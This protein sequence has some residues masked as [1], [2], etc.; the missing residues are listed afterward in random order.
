MSNEDPMDCVVEFNRLVKDLITP[1]LKEIGFKR[2]GLNFARNSNDII[3]TFGIQKERFNSSDHLSFKL[4][5][6]LLSEEIFREILKK[7]M[8]P[9]PLEVFSTIRLFPDS[10]SPKCK[11]KH[12]FSVYDE[13]TSNEI[14]ARVQNEIE[15][16]YIPFF[17]KYNSTNTWAELLD[18]NLKGLFI[19]PAIQRFLVYLKIGRPIQAAEALRNTY[20]FSLL[21]HSKTLKYYEGR[22]KG[23][24]LHNATSISRESIEQIERFAEKYHISLDKDLA[25]KLSS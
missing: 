7:E 20:S 19:V 9:F 1:Q 12:T 25:S 10:V 15:H 21:E 8:P 16:Y 23:K 11:N 4:N 3:Q 5:I 2:K 22:L 24:R 13:A 17:E 18:L 6:G 14:F